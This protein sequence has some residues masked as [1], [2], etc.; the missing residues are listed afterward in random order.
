MMSAMEQPGLGARAGSGFG[1]GHPVGTRAEFLAFYR[2]AVRPAYRAA[3]RLC[4]GDR[5]RSEDLVQEAF[6]DLV[7]EVRSGRITTVDV[8]WVIVAVR[9]RF[10]DSLRR[11]EREERKLRLVWS[12]QSAEGDSHSGWPNDDPS[13]ERVLRHLGQLPDAQRAAIVLHHVD[14][15]SVGQVAAALGRSSHATE[16]LLARGRD[17]LRRLMQ[18]E[19]P[20]DD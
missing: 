14:G 13:S 5:A 6:L 1:A 10:I 3:S 11:G 12:R 8:G 2:L 16:S 20:N 18:T 7:R 4:G 15:L 17:Q 9:H 19:V